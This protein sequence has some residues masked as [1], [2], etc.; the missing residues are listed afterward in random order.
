MR[1]T[2]VTLAAAVALLGAPGAAEAKHTGLPVPVGGVAAAFVAYGEGATV[3]HF[4]VGKR[5]SSTAY[6]GV[7]THYK[8]ETE[9]T[10]PVEQTGHAT[11]P[12]TSTAPLLDGG[13]CSGYRTTCTSDGFRMGAFN[14]NPVTYRVTLR[15]PY[16]QGWVGAPTSCQGVGTDILR[17]EYS[18]ND[19]FVN[20]NSIALQ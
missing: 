4:T 3:C 6:L 13:L 7:G 14:T 12:A 2:L 1:K 19:V 18:I 8:G 5:T 16:G 10:G 9:C 20:P 11:V 15:A 17:C